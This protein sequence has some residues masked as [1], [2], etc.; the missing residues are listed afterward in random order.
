MKPS[1]LKR[2]LADKLTSEDLV[3]VSTSFDVVGDIAILRV[4]PVVEH[5]KALIAKAVMATNTHVKTVLHQQSSVAGVFRLRALEH[6]A[7]KRTTA[8]LHRE[9]GC[10]FKVDLAKAYFSPRLAFERMRVGTLVKQEERVVNMFAGVGC[11]SI[12]IAKHSPTRK[13]YSIDLNPA[14]VKLMRENIVL[15]RLKRRVEAICGD[16]R[17]VV[18]ERFLNAVDRVVM[19]LP[20]KAYEYLDIAVKALHKSQG[21]IHYYE[22]I[23]AGRGENPIE[24]GVDKIDTKLMELRVNYRVAASRIVR[25]VGPRW[26]QIALDIHVHPP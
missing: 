4:P 20:E 18:A 23:H 10:V 21:V 8:T 3:Q 19:P 9:Y 11:F 5:W 13:V 24:K 15:N 25:M 2:Y 17:E 16:A 14:A 12:I 1:F 26:Y 22:F 6:V 7:G